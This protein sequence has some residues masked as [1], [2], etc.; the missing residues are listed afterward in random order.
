MDYTSE[1]YINF[2]GFVP[3]LK[4]A[5]NSHKINQNQLC[6]E[7]YQGY[8]VHDNGIEY[9][10]KVPNYYALSDEQIKKRIYTEILLE[11]LAMNVGLNVIETKV[12]LINKKD[13]LL[14][15]ISQ[16][17]LRKGYEVT[18]GADII[19]EYLDFLEK[20]KDPFTKKN[21]L[22]LYFQNKS[23]DDVLEGFKSKGN[24]NSLEFIWASLLYHFRNSK[25]KL[26]HVESIMQKLTKR[27]IFQFLMMQQDFHLKN[28]EI[29][30]NNTSAFLS[31]MYDLDMGFH[32]K[33]NS[34]R[35]NSM[36]SYMDE[37]SSIYDDFKRFYDS[38]SLEI[39]DE[40][41]KQISLLPPEV[42]L[43]CMQIIENKYLYTFP[44]ELKEEF[45]KKYTEHYN[46][47]KELTRDYHL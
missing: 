8:W 39:Q 22:Y 12:A 28:W 45:L 11:E 14:G 37:V 6:G 9:F 43:N 1:G 34:K 7:Y 20:S 24:Y 16:S 38:S 17:Y 40:V 25:N 13:H 18:T 44:S 29:L 46:R 27:Y 23:K 21:L 2:E 47:M 10:L 32:D 30:E 4:Q 5:K 26:A 33:F 41:K 36:R 35:N 19:E 42:I 3:D 15:M 31:P